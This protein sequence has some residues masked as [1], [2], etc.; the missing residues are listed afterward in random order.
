[1]PTTAD[2]LT[3]R[4][5]SHE[6]SNEPSA[7]RDAAGIVDDPR[8]RSRAGDRIHRRELLPPRLHHGGF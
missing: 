4:R 2:L 5:K 6:T 3:E 7:L 8:V 1:M